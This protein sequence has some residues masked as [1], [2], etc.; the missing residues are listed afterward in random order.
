M[1][2]PYLLCP[3][4]FSIAL[5]SS[6]CTPAPD[7]WVEAKPSQN[8]ILVSF[9]PLYCITHA[10]AGDDAYVLCLLTSQ[11][12]HD[13]DGGPTDPLKVAD[14]DLVISNG[15]GLDDAFVDKML[16]A[17][18]TSPKTLNVGAVMEK[19]IL[20][21][22]KG[23]LHDDGKIHIHGQHDPHIWLGPEQAI[24]M[25]RII[26]GKLADIDPAH[27]EGYAEREEKFIEELKKLEEHGKTAFKDKTHKNIVTMHES[28]GYFV[29]PFGLTVVRPIQAKPGER[30]HYKTR[31]SSGA[32]RSSWCSSIHWRRRRFRRGNASIPIRAIT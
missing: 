32:S 17:A 14:A 16:R 25:T 1:R 7:F 23:H 29:K 6:G 3:L 28:F 10:V 26:A 19:N 24:A 8:K 2:R 21:E 12:P 27:K 20:H 18:R 15:L 30:R 4:L 5:G 11:G 13:Y 9:P 22:D 31:S